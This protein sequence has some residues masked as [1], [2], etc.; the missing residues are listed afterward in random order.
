M[1]LN[2]L[3]YTY[4]VLDGQPAKL[5]DES[6]TRFLASVASFFVVFSCFPS[7]YVTFSTFCNVFVVS[8]PITLARCLSAFSIFVFYANTGSAVCPIQAD[9]Q[10]HQSPDSDARRGEGRWVEGDYRG[11]EEAGA[12]SCGGGQP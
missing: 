1:S 3:V 11:V 6:F 9:E 2:V 10:G 5:H 7:L 8:I 12:S 4:P